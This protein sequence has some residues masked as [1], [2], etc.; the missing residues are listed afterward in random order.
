[1]EEGRG[2]GRGGNGRGSADEE[3][4]V[5]N[6]HPSTVDSSIRIRETKFLD[7][8]SFLSSLLEKG[9]KRYPSGQP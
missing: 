4:R 8:L 3:D 6:S 1:M 7:R 5:C 2:G 9:A